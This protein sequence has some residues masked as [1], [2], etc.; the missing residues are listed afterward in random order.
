MKVL[1]AVIAFQIVVARAGGKCK[2]GKDASKAAPAEYQ[3]KVESGGSTKFTADQAKIMLDTMNKMRCAVGSKPIKWSAK[4]ASQAQKSQDTI[5]ALV[6]DKSWLLPISAGEALCGLED[7]STSDLGKAFGE[8]IAHAAWAWFFE[9]TQGG[10]NKE[11]GKCG[12]YADITWKLATRVGCGIGNKV[13]RCQFSGDKNGDNGRPRPD[14][15]GPEGPAANV[16]DF[17]GPKSA[18]EKCGLDFAG[19]KAAMCVYKKWGVTHPTGEWGASL[20]G[21]YDND[22]PTVPMPFSQTG[23]L[24]VGTA[25]LSMVAT[26]AVVGFRRF[27]GRGAY[28]AAGSPDAVAEEDAEEQLLDDSVQ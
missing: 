27:R 21:K 4:L 15:T 26:A 9:Y 8:P 2:V 14:G 20:M 28:T 1:A 13:I 12:H 17:K 22:V 10:C 6:H 7:L 18:Y 25:L 16:P 5:G 3:Q 24:V 19:A 23:V 11:F